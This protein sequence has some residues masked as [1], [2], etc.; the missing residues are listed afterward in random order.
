MLPKALSLLRRALPGVLM[1]AGIVWFSEALKPGAKFEVGGQLPS[2]TVKLVDGTQLD[3]A[4]APGTPM[5]L[6]FWASYCAPCRAEAQ[7]L[8]ALHAR[9]VRV[10]GLS[11]DA[12]SETQ[13]TAAARDF[14]MP[15]PVGLGG[16]LVQPMSVRTIP[17]TYVLDAKGRILLSRTGVVSHRDLDEALAAAARN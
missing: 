1:I 7:V 8:A 12:R 11:V 16:A 3:L 13:L 2:L 15:Y 5:V 9:G 14:G 6:N 4:A 17:T 10:V